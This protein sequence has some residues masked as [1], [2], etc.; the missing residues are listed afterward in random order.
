MKISHQE[1]VQVTTWVL[2]AIALAV[3]ANLLPHHVAQEML[4]KLR[5]EWKARFT[6][7][8]GDALYQRRRGVCRVRFSKPL[9]KV[10]P[11]NERRE[12]AYHEVAHLVVYAAW[13]D[14]CDVER[15]SGRRMPKRPKPHGREWKRVM[16]A[17]G[18]PNPSVTHTLR[19]EEVERQRGK[20]QV[21]C[22][23]GSFWITQRRAA[24]LSGD[25]GLHCTKCKHLV[26]HTREAVRPF[27]PRRRPRRRVPVRSEL[28]KLISF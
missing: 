20:V 26:A 18:Y 6:A 9:W 14:R 4:G 24:K 7:R 5:I 17:M 21:F 13:Q 25:H 12:T 2:D 10:A 28:E 1:R 8:L 15:L 22:M 3:S 23:C 19:N 11:E 16:R 27:R